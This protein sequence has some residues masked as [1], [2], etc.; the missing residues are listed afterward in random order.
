MM[1]LCLVQKL[2]GGYWLQASEN[3]SSKDYL[4]QKENP[5]TLHVSRSLVEIVL[6]AIL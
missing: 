4:G 3:D 5:A 2:L 6:C 1:A